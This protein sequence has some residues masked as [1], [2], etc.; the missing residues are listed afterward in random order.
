MKYGVPKYNIEKQE[1]I[2]QVWLKKWKEVGG[3]AGFD[4]AIYDSRLRRMTYKE[5]G[6]EFGLGSNTISKHYRRYCRHHRLP[7]IKYIYR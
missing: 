5:I 4:K 3:D 1:L 6:E 2:Y 7:I